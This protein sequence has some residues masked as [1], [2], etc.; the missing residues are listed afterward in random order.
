MG[1][2][3][4]PTHGAARGNWKSPKSSAIGR[5]FPRRARA[6]P[7]FQVFGESTVAD[8][9]GG[10]SPV[11]AAWRSALQ[12]PEDIEEHDGE[13][14]LE[15]HGS[16]SPF[17]PALPELSRSIPRCPRPPNPTLADCRPFHFYRSGVGRGSFREK[18]HGLP[19]LQ[20]PPGNGGLR[21]RA[22]CTPQGRLRTK[23]RPGELSECLQDQQGRVVVENRPLPEAVEEPLEQT[24]RRAGGGACGSSP[25]A[26]PPGAANRSRANRGSRP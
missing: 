22:D 20:W 14:D 11:A 9:P 25:R 19:V 16:T 3:D 1:S 8:Q 15:D 26:D 17:A 7:T 23:G 21:E 10:G 12:P 5:V 24:V 6:P 4:Y 13:Q 2:I 18:C